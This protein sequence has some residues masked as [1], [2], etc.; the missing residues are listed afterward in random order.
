MSLFDNTAT[1][2]Q[3][4][5]DNIAETLKELQAKDYTNADEKIVNLVK[6]AQNGN[7][8]ALFLCAQAFQLGAGV[9]KDEEFYLRH[10]NAS[11]HG[12]NQKAIKFLIKLYT[13]G[14]VAPADSDKALYWKEQLALSGDMEAVQELI[15]YHSIMG[16]ADSA[17]KIML[18]TQKAAELG[19]VASAIRMAQISMENGDMAQFVRYTELAAENGFAEAQYNLGIIYY[20]G[21]ICQPDGAKAFHWTKKAAQ[22]GLGNAMF[23]LAVMY[24]E[25]VGCE[26]SPEMSAHW[27]EKAANCDD[28]SVRQMVRQ[29]ME[30]SAE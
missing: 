7:P 24:A 18:F 17:E 19:D 16:D 11:A 2:Q 6:T 13:D 28:E 5:M 15:V 8:D 27:L 30:E 25:G 9:A 20:A 29:V 1:N 12:G 4:M 3:E 21:E 23:N 22:A 26:K 10:Y 14:G